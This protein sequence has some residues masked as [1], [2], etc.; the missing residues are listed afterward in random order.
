MMEFVSLPIAIGSSIISEWIDLND[1][2]ML[3]SACNSRSTRSAY[4]SYCQFGLLKHQ[5]I[6]LVSYEQIQWFLTRK[7][8]IR[9]LST[10]S[11]KWQERVDLALSELLAVIGGNVKEISFY[12]DITRLSVHSYCL[13]TIVAQNCRNIQKVEISDQSTDMELSPLLFLLKSVSEWDISYCNITS[14]SLY[15][16]A[17]SSTETIKHISLYATNQVCDIGI[18]ALAGKCPKLESLCIDH[19]EPVTARGVLTLIRTTS[20]I[21]KL[22]LGIDNLTDIDITTIAQHCPMLYSLGIDAP[23]VTDAGIHAIVSSCTQLRIIDLDNCM[24][25]TTGFGLFRNLHE[26]RIQNSPTLTDTMVATIVQNNPFL[27]YVRISQCTS[28]KLTYSAVLCILQGCPHLHFLDFYN[29]TMTLVGGTILP[30][31]CGDVYRLLETV[32]KQQYPHVT[33]V[34]IVLK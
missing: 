16:L 26:F 31:G 4:L 34:N 9:K 18:T 13:N 2:V 32:I 21:S 5:C 12:T 29:A 3:D 15:A 6:E 22:Y 25:I 30:D 20:N 33:H 23:L 14:A 28:I 17:T 27:E 7:L 11:L 1:L 8:M 24:N 19:C 10:S